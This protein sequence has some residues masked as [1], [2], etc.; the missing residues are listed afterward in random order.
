MILEHQHIRYNPLKDEWILVSPHRTQRPWDG[1]LE[2]VEE[3]VVEFDP[4]NPLC[5]GVKR[6]SGLTNPE[7]KSTYVF[8]NDFPAIVE[9]VPEPPQ[10]NDE[11]FQTRAARGTCKVI[12]FHP[13]S[14]I[15]LYSMTHDEV[16]N[17]IQ[18][19][20]Q[21]IQ[22]LGKKYEWVQ[23]FENRGSMMGCS[24]PHPHCQ[25]W[26]SNF[27]P[28]EAKIKDTNL[29]KYYTK[30]QRPL[31]Q[32]YI[33][34]ELLKKER[35][36]YENDEWVILVP[37]WAVWPFETMILPKNQIERLTDANLRQRELLVAT[38]QILIAKY[39][40]LFK[41][42]FPYSM[43][44]HGAPTGSFLNEPQTHWTFH[45]IYYPPLLR[46]ANIKKFM[47]GYELLAQP[48]RDLTPEKA[49]GML[50]E[51]SPVHFKLN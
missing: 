26:A 48:Q 50:R 34:K 51:Q 28:N 31:L 27:M 8:T 1:E 41:C 17:V 49:A 47:V 24:N 15:H 10:T 7:Y 12:C 2:T 40:N 33:K 16:L 6:S 20:M 35:I 43:G 11:L 13:R 46:S 25:V 45:G 42:T 5:P 32:D 38:L 39:D 44:W 19:W 9:N 23:L 22:E 3:K 14:N 18:E 37:Y 29:K 36:V 4:N 30:H 21:Q